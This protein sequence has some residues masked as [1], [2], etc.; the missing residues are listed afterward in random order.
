MMLMTL[1]LFLGAPVMSVCL[2]RTPLQPASSAPPGPPGRG[3][4][5]R[6][7]QAARRFER[8]LLR[9][10]KT[11]DVGPS[12]PAGP[13]GRAPRACPGRPGECRA[14]MAKNLYALGPG[15]QPPHSLLRHP[16]CNP[17]VPRLR[18]RHTN[19]LT[20]CGVQ[21]LSCHS[22]PRE[23]L[24]TIL[25]PPIRATAL[26]TAYGLVWGVPG[27]PPGRL[28]ADGDLGRGAGSAGVP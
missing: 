25:T 18:H 2:S 20:Q 7:R 26:T 19:D 9:I 27:E 14:A 23:R 22:E 12:P 11:L 21:T 8:A 28:R 5:R 17:N 10:G 4:Q 1:L 15:F 6:P 3:Q 24:T 16:K 13:I